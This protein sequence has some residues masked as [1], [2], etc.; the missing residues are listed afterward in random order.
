MANS[1]CNTLVEA[2]PTDTKGGVRE[3]R[4]WRK[5]SSCLCR[6]LCLQ[7]DM[8]Q[9]AMTREQSAEPSSLKASCVA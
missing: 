4:Y 8:T 5:V 3:V 9:H 1:L 6:P 2:T 7:E